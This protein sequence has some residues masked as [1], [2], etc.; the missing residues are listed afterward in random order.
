VRLV[1]ASGSPRRRDLLRSVG[2]EPVVVPADV[3]ETPL[4][5]EEPLAY[6][7]RL[8]RAKADAVAGG[9]V[10]A[11]DTTVVLDGA[12]LGKPADAAEATRMLRALGGRTH[13]VCTGVCVRHGGAHAAGSATTAV[14]FEPL[15]EADVGWYVGT[16]EP[17][18]KAGAYAIQGGG[19]L[20]VAAVEGS[21]SNVVGLPLHLVRRLL[22]EVGVDLLDLRRPAGR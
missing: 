3:D 7:T 14:T 13:L 18:D 19:G 6:V 10:L 16:G 22:E 21:F 5:G 20:F 4:P 17:F 15:T 1:L 2:V 12:L 8:A 9:L 11:A